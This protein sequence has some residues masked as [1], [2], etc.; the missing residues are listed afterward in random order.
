M[1][2]HVGIGIFLPIHIFILLTCPQKKLGQIFFSS[3]LNQTF[4]VK[5]D[6]SI[7]F[8]FTFLKFYILKNMTISLTFHDL[9]ASYY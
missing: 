5:Y 3:S 1:D 6:Q 9:N 2:I 7:C 4:L 8:D